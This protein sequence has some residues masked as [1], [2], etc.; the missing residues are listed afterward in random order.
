MVPS[1]N[2]V[3]GSESKSAESVKMCYLFISDLLP[4][5][6]EFLV[7][8]LATESLSLAVNVLR[9]VVCLFQTCCQAL[10]SSL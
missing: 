4:G 2:T 9:Y 10:R 3:E 1:L 7:T 6:E 5:I 8:T